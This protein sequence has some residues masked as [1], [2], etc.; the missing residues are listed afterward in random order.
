MTTEKE[1]RIYYQNIVYRVCAVLDALDGNR[2][3]NSLCCGSA[4]S[5]CDDVERRMEKLL[6]KKEE[7]VEST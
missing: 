6:G 4:D 7:L 5:P 3:G 2:P 1:K